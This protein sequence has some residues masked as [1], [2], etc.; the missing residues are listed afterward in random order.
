M[1]DPLY[2]TLALLAA[3]SLFTAANLGLYLRAKQHAASAA[4]HSFWAERQ[5]DAAAAHAVRAQAVA[6]RIAHEAA[7]TPVALRPDPPRRCKACD[8]VLPLAFVH[9][10]TC[11]AVAPSREPLTPGEVRD[12]NAIVRAPA[13]EHRAG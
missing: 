6:D 9:C 8:A 3:V 7:A 13:D 12:V 11:N 2:L 5:A 1:P 10:H 4:Y